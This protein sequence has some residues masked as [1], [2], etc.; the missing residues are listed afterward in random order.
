MYKII[1]ADQKEYGPVTKEQLVQWIADGRVNAQ[2]LVQAEGQTAWQPLSAFPEFSTTIP[3]AAA[4]FATPLTPPQPDIK[5]H[6]QGPGIALLVLGI[7]VTLTAAANLVSHVVASGTQST[8]NPQIDQILR[9]MQG[10][11]GVIAAIAQI[12]IGGLITFGGVRLRQARSYGLVV[13]ST[14]L[15]MIPCTSGC[16]CLAG[17]P[18]GIWVLVVIM[19]PEVKAGFLR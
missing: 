5:S 9:S 16:C 14:I 10:P 2:T 19:K 13:A 12:A 17:L 18:I 7:L 11:I 6:V 8:G 15:A 4:P 1:G 3:T